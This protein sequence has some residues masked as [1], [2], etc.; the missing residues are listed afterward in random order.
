V[1]PYARSALAGAAS[2]SRTFT[3]L[4][5]LALASPAGSPTQPDRTL[6]K[7]W[8][9]GLIAVAAVQ[10]IVMDK[11]PMAPSRLQ[12]IA[13]AGRIAAAAGAGVIVARRFRAPADS[14]ALTPPAGPT[15]LEQA[16]HAVV[17]AAAGVVTAVL[18]TRWR[19]WA[20][21]DV[22]PDPVAAAI[23]DSVAISLAALAAR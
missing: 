7:H 21:P 14:E 4:A 2:G 3:G 16:R 19:A 11:L 22:G 9:K 18:G 20:V 5:A 1:N 12:P 6:E 13:L 8:V 15:P 17:A 10:E 23:E